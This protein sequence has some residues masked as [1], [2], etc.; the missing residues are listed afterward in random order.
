M[1]TVSRS[2]KE[3]EKIK[4]IREHIL[5]PPPFFS[6]VYISKTFSLHQPTIL[7]YLQLQVSKFEIHGQ[8]SDSAVT[9]KVKKSPNRMIKENAVCT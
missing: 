4:I 3:N 5:I 2:S 9:S 1:Q 8:I 7:H 6:P